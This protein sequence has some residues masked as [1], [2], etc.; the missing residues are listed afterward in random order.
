M[1]APVGAT[2]HEVPAWRG[3]T[4]EIAIVPAA[5]ATVVLAARASSLLGT[6]AM[7][8]HGGSLVL[9]LVTSAVYHRHCRD[10]TTR[11]LARR[12]DHAAI[13]V[14]IAGSYVPMTLLVVPSPVSIILLVVVLAVATR[15]VVMKLMHLELGQDR[16]HSW[17]Y[18]ALGWG[19]VVL[20]PWVIT[21]AGWVTLIFVVIGGA[22]YT[23]GGLVLIAKRP[24]PFPA[25][26][27][28]HEIW[29]VFVLIGAAVHLGVSASVV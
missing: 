27:G 3:L 5:I 1:T 6:V 25:T 29:H 9:L 14:L 8:I 17:L 20:V 21:E 24:N 11:R 15:G 22:A 7:A 2:T 12:A 26:F 23:I 18:A 16:F 10:E 4:H 13:F 28:Y 19:G